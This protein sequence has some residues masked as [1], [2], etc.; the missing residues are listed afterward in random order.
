MAAGKRARWHTVT[1]M[2]GKTMNNTDASNKAEDL[3]GRGKEALGD[4]TNDRD[5]Q[6]EGKADQ[7]SSKV[8]QAVNDAGDAIS[9]GIDKLRG[10]K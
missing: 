4:L 7:S 5:L 2:E 10:K 9:D 1:S 3:K 8:K 6:R